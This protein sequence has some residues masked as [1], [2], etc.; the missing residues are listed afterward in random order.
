MTKKESFNRG[1]VFMLL[2]AAGLALT[3]LLGKVGL[4]Y[5]NITALI[6]WRYLVSCILCLPLIWWLGGFKEGIQVQN[7]KLHFLRAFLVLTTQYFYYYYLQKNTILNAMVLV[8]TGPLFIP[9]IERVFLKQRVGVSTWVSLVI[10]FVGVLFVLQ[11][12]K[13]LFSQLGWMGL[14][15]G[16]TQGASQVVFGMNS[17]VERSDL[18][19]LYLMFFCMLISLFPFLFWG[20]TKVSSQGFFLLDWVLVG[21]GIASILNQLARAEAYQHGTPSRLSSFLYASVLLAGLWDWIFFNDIPNAFSIMGAILVVLG[22]L[23]KIYLRFRILKQK[24]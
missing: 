6:F 17:K 14:L 7:I 11:P 2:S 24:K 8:N 3:G 4:N 20:E 16:V 19:V 9:I 10:S 23:S 12:D 5:M 15:A 22:G 21:L 13:D 1:V 18:G